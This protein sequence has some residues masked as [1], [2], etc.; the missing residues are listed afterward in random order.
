MY[1]VPLAAVL[2][3]LA[4][5]GCRRPAAPAPAAP[6]PVVLPEP[7]PAPTPAPVALPEAAGP[8]RRLVLWD[9][10]AHASGGPWVSPVSSNN[11]LRVQ[12]GDTHQGQAA[13]ELRGE[14]AGWIGGG[15]NWHNWWPADAGT[16]LR[17]YSNLVFWIR[18][19]GDAPGNL[20]VKLVCPAN[21]PS[22]ATVD[23]TLYLAGNANPSDGQWH[24]VVIPFRALQADA[25]GFEL[26]SVSELDVGAWA[27][28]P[29]SFRVYLDDLAVDDR[30]ARGGPASPAAGPV[31]RAEPTVS[32]PLAVTATLDL[33]A[34]GTPISPYIYGAAMGDRTVATDA[35]L[36]T[37][38]A[39]G[40]PLTPLNWK[41][42]FGSKGADW[43][44]Q[45]EG[46][47]TPPAEN[48]LV[49]FHGANR[50]AGLETYLSIPCMGRVAKDGT[51]VAFDTRK[52]PDQTSWAGQSQPGDR[53][54][55]AGN[56]RQ[57]VRDPNGDIRNDAAN[58]PLTRA[59][60]AN[61][62]D[63]SVVMSPAEQTD[64]LRFLIEDMG[65]GR[66]AQGGVRFVALDNE[67]M[68]WHITHRGMRPQ[69]CSYDELWERTRT[70]ASRLK[71]LDPGVKIAGPTAWGWTAY[72][73]SGVDA[74][75][76][77]EGRATW[78]NPPDFTAHGR[79]P[80]G[81]WWLQKLNAYEREHGVR[82]VDILDWHFYPQTGLY[83]GGKR[84]DP[85]TMEARVQQT[86]VLW[87]PTYHD[88]S[89]MGRETGK[90]IQLIRLMKDWI[91]ECNPGMQTALGEY[92]FSGEDDISGGVAQAELLG[93]FAR[94]GLDYA[95]Y[96]FFPQAGSSPYFSF[97][98]YRNPD[99]RHTAF[100]DR[101][102]P[103]QV[104]APLDVSVHAARDTASG[105]LSVVLINKRAARD[106]RVTL[107]LS[108]AVP[109]QNV[110]VYEY[111]DVDRFAIGQW[112]A[113][114]LGGRQ[115]VINV[116]ALSV[117][118]FDLQP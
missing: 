105:R 3:V 16:D 87:D 27:G 106:A 38:R 47:E 65:Y 107:N 114:R 56:G 79:V 84:N 10:E 13:L 23:P 37:L 58:A 35:G 117:L 82:L 40:N 9:G 97:K 43:F 102:L 64:L 62:D 101:Y 80:L 53:S 50:K 112:P 113:R 89:W 33:A 72:F 48:W 19:A 78:D 81:K 93:V 5:A 100:G 75:A 59:V 15:W 11:A 66:A 73:Y 44:F 86:R 4:P 60:A 77:D 41:R 76:V 115:V 17:S 26:A 2:A 95:F 32:D 34:V 99:G 71:Q 30:P 39:G 18:L 54:P 24:E 98:M 42:G 118:R 69:A 51:S 67:P 90:V 91:A 104:S 70:Y 94:E 36:T 61:P 1:A 31:T 6:A 109:E 116:P 25:P 28:A 68:L 49:T 52:Y 74:Q 55:H 63:T 92:C 45:N 57:Y 103:V 83:A 14:G 88:P 46:T 20:N 7:Q 21:K 111:R 110:V 8:T 85:A 29:R 108:K 22:S 12:D 96:W